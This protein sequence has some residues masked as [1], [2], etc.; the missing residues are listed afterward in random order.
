MSGI[1][2]FV[3]HYKEN[4]SSSL[5][6]VLI[7]IRSSTEKE[8]RN[9]HNEDLITL[10]SGSACSHSLQNVLYS[11]VLLE[12]VRHKICKADSRPVVLHVFEIWPVTTRE[13]HRFWVS[14]NR[15]LRCLFLLGKIK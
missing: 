6:C 12:N 13:E 1:L 3:V 15:V 4:T 14:E 7:N 5:V 9:H 10:N 11:Y 2:Y 8:K